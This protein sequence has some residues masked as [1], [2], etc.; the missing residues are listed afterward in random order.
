MTDGHQLKLLLVTSHH[1]HPGP[2]GL[3]KLPR[4]GYQVGYIN[5]ELGDVL[6]GEVAEGPNGVFRLQYVHREIGTEPAT[7]AGGTPAAQEPLR[8]LD[9]VVVTGVDP[10]Q[11]LAFSAVTA[12]G[13]RWRC[14]NAAGFAANPPPQGATAEEVPGADYRVWAKSV[15]NEEGEAQRR[16]ANRTAMH[17]RRSRTGTRA[18]AAI[19]DSTPA[20]TVMV[21]RAYCTTWGQHADA[22]W[23]ELLHPARRHQKFSRFR[24]QQ[25]EAAIAKMAKRLAPI[26]RQHRP[27]GWKRAPARGRRYPRRREGKHRR[28]RET[29]RRPR[30]I[31]FFGA[32][33]RFPA[34][35]RAAI[36]IKKLAAQLACRCPT[37][38]T[39][40][41]YSFFS[42]LVCGGPT[43]SGGDEFGP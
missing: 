5:E 4:R 16:G 15:R 32:C 39:P 8:A 13:Q 41:P 24:A 22:M 35:G 27:P 18:W 17:L 43:Q 23:G 21:L 34:C 2:H 1:S 25:P 12:L 36:P 38:I 40:E 26:Q 3:T 7:V 31:I 28:W 37:L 9:H 10:G 30:R 20:P 6:E 33:A 14:E 29:H 19:S 11:V 42:C